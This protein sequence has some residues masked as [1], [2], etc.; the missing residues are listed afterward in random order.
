MPPTPGPSPSSTESCSGMSIDPVT[1]RRLPESPTRTARTGSCSGIARGKA[2]LAVQ[3][4]SELPRRRGPIPA[5]AA[6]PPRHDRCRRRLSSPTTGPCALARS[7]ILRIDRRTPRRSCTCSPTRPATP[8][9]S[10]CRPTILVEVA[11]DRGLSR[12]A[13][14]GSSGS[15]LFRA[16]SSP[17][18]PLTVGA[19]A[20]PC[21]KRFNPGSRHGG[22]ARLRCWQDRG[23]QRGE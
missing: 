21:L 13:V 8:S 11:L 9:A 14:G 18:H 3:H 10:S 20:V 2:R 7:S 5:S 16:C 6:A 4:V 1:S 15:D 12:R 22:E 17:G 19:A 23:G